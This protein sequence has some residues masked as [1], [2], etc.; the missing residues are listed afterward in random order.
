MSDTVTAGVSRAR[1][2]R[3]NE[4]MQRCIDTTPVPGI[5]TPSA[6][7][8]RAAGAAT[9]ALAPST[10]AAQAAGAHSMARISPNSCSSFSQPSPPSTERNTWPLTL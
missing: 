10:R 6:E 1:L 3:I 7:A 8:A 9:G 4:A 2:D 5:T